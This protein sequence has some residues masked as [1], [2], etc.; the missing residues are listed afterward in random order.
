MQQLTGQQYQQARQSRDPRFDG[1][2]FVGVKTTGIFCRNICPV[3]LPKEENVEYFDLA[4]QAMH[5]GFRPCLRCRPDSAPGSFAW[6]GV[7]TTLHR[8]MQ[9]LKQHP[10]M[11]LQPLCEKLGITDRYLRKLFQ[12]RLGISPKHFQVT[13]QLL[14]AKR[15]LHETHLTIEQ[16]AQSSGFNSS[17]RLQDNMQQHFRLTPS[18]VRK[19]ETA[20]SGKLQLKLAFREPYNWPQMRDFLSFRIIAGVEEV[21]DDSYR[22]HFTFEHSQGVT[23]GYFIAQ[24][25]LKERCFHLQLELNDYSQLGAVIRNIRRVLDLDTDSNLVTSQLL[26]AGIPAEQIVEGLR[27]PGVWSLFEAGV[28]AILGQQVSVKAAIGHV[29]K[30]VQACNNELNGRL[31]FPSPEQ[32]LADPLDCLKM[33][34]ARK[35]SLHRLAEFCAQLNQD[36]SSA[37]NKDS[38]NKNDPE[39]WLALKG[40]G[41]WTIAYAKMRGLSDPDVWLN[42]DL[43]IKKQLQ[44]HS[45]DSDLVAPWHSYLTF[46]LWSMA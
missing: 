12:D 32:I 7:E 8:A 25:I 21:T 3:K 29:T 34:G 15:L 36:D 28:R 2:F 40:I 35:Q 19:Q 10:E 20:S 42:T 43:V 41:P 5:A 23:S 24:H 16:V 38:S 6:Q 18:Q 31:Q 9:L 37:P 33:P 17:R 46:Q 44:L 26:A 14:F 22:R 4:A 30:L 11:E 13:E 45:I 39:H 1:R 27:L